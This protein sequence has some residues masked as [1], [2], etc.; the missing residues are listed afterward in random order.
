MTTYIFNIKLLL[1]LKDILFF[2]LSMM[3]E[4]KLETKICMWENI[5]LGLMALVFL[6]THFK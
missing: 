5:Q 4:T 6:K 2:R 3:I 1:D